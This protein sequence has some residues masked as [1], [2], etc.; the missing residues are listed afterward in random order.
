MTI[1]SQNTRKSTRHANHIN[2]SHITRHQDFC[3]ILTLISKDWAVVSLLFSFLWMFL[4][5]ICTFLQDSRFRHFPL[6]MASWHLIQEADIAYGRA[7]CLCSWVLHTYCG[8]E[9]SSVN[10]APRSVS[11]SLRHSHIPM[12]G[13]DNSTTPDRQLFKINDAKFSIFIFISKS[14]HFLSFLVWSRTDWC[15]SMCAITC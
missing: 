4:F 3:N 10:R 6:L 11:H 1:T 15:K 14:V 13:D 12:L 8:S 2:S 9:L 5:I 7:G